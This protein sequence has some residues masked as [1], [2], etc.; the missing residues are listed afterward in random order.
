LVLVHELGH[1]FAARMVDFRV[2]EMIAGPIRCQVSESGSLKLSFNRDRRFFL[3]GQVRARPRSGKRLL[4]KAICMLAAGPATHPLIALLAGGLYWAGWP[5]QPRVLGAP[6]F[7][8]ALYSATRTFLGLLPVSHP[9]TALASDAR[10]ILGLLRREPSFVVPWL[11]AC[12]MDNVF[13][14][15]RPREWGLL[16]KEWLDITE[17]EIADGRGVL[18]LLIL[19]LDQNDFESART[20]LARGLERRTR[21]EPPVQHDLLVQAAAFHALFDNDLARAQS[22]Y[23]AIS[24][25]TQITSYRMIAQAALLLARGDREASKQTLDG[26]LRSLEAI[27]QGALYRLGNE[28]IIDRLTGVNANANASEVAQGSGQPSPLP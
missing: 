17:S 12:V 7:T 5:W 18:F 24:S 9:R 26:W 1:W 14:H 3:A 21:F 20:L 6:L 10:Q 25:I 11:R 27:P 22:E 2:V 28:W 19:A 13:A 16:A 15:R 4:P 8:I 23:D